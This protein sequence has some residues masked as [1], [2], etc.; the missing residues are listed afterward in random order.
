MTAW[1]FDVDGVLCNTNELA[2]TE[3]REWFVAWSQDKRYYLVTGG[4]R[5]KTI[6]QLGSTIVDGAEMLFNCIGNC[7]W[8]NGKETLV[9]QFAL[10]QEERSWLELVLLSSRFPLRTGWHIDL[11]EGS[12]NYSIVGRNANLEQRAQYRD[13]DRHHQE[14]A[15]IARD[16][17]TRFPRFEAYLGGD[18]S[19]DVCLRGA[20]KGRCASVIR[21]HAQ[22]HLYFFGDKCHP[23]GI[24]EPF[25]KQCREELGDRVFHVSGY[26]ETWNIL[27]EIYST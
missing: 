15:S 18:T 3:F 10:T 16:F 8:H 4:R 20:N 11:R 5:E 27:N 25:V 12:M 21:Q 24:D 6:L 22:D 1:V 13:W 2:T 23:G 17:V 19:I 14:R 9:N 26:K 7:V